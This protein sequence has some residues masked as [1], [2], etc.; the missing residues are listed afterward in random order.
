M[1]FG[2]INK[3]AT[4]QRLMNNVFKD[5]IGDMLEVYMQDMIVKSKQEVH[6]ITHLKKVFE[7]A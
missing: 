1:S 3:G 6:Q 2:R 4:Y 5:V 7:Q